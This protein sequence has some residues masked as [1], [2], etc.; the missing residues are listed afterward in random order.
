MKKLSHKKVYELWV[1][2]LP[3]EMSVVVAVEGICGI[4]ESGW[5]ELI[6]FDFNFWR[7]TN[8]HMAIPKNKTKSKIEKEF[9]FIRKTLHRDCKK[10]LRE[11]GWGD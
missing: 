10:E 9:S 7:M 11:R 4:E 5:M 2:S 3:I 6:R 8:G 1:K